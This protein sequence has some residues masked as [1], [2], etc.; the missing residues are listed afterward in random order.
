[1]HFT[2][3]KGFAVL[4]YLF[5]IAR[6]DPYTLVPSIKDGLSGFK[7]LLTSKFLTLLNNIKI[8]ILVFTVAV[9]NHVLL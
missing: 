9:P 1:M 5:S 3:F 8:L 2:K 6:F 7:F 4:T